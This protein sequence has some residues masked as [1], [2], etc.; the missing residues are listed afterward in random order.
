MKRAALILL[1]L[2]LLLL[3]LWILESFL[4]YAWRHPISELF[5]RLFPSQPYPQHDMGLE[6]EMFFREHP[7]WRI[8]DYVLTAF[9]ATANAFLI[10]KVWNALRQPLSPPPQN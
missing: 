5:D 7:L 2:A 3:E 1:F 6:F 4:P 9:L 8:A 10:S